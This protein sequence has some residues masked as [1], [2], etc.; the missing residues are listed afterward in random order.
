MNTFPKDNSAW[1]LNGCSPHMTDTLRKAVRVV[2]QGVRLFTLPPHAPDLSPIEKSFVTGESCQPLCAC[3]FGIRPCITVKILL[4][5]YMQ[6]PTD[7]FDPVKLLEKACSR[8]YTHNA[9]GLYEQSGYALD[10]TR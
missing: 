7:K 5:T 6:H 2:K 9:K 4:Q 10:K 1:V 3:K 8:Y